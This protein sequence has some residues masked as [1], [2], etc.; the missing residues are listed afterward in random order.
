MKKDDFAIRLGSRIRELRKLK[1][2]SQLELVYDMDMSM[3]TISGIELGKISPKVETLM[4]IANKLDIDIAE[5][6]DFSNVQPKDKIIRKKVEEIS[7][8]LLGQDKEFIDLV[9]QSIE[10]LHKAHK[11]K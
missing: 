3:N 6:F 8:K 5:I 4:K 10:I 1:G 9:A 11:L 2:I 7:H